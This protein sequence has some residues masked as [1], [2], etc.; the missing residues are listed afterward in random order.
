[1]KYL[2]VILTILIT[3]GLNTYAQNETHNND[4]NDR[5]CSHRSL[6]LAI[7]NY[8]I[9]FGNSENFSGI[10]LNFRDCG[11]GQ[12]NGINLTSE[13]TIPPHS[14]YCLSST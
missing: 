13:K 10:R 7:D 12:I 9:S 3:F 5:Y 1:M 8:G 4:D 14:R 2:A 6:D 11:I